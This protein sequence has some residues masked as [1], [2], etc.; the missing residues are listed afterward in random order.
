MLQQINNMPIGRRLSLIV[1]LIS[2][3]T[4]GIVSYIALISTTQTLRN[5]AL[6]TLHNQS[7]QIANSIDRRMQTVQIIL[8]RIRNNVDFEDRVTA[9][10]MNEAISSVMRLETNLIV[11]RVSFYIPG[12]P[13]I[14]HNFPNA[15][16]GRDSLT[17]QINES[18]FGENAWVREVVDS[19]ETGWYGPENSLFTSQVEPTISLVSRY[20]NPTTG[21][22]GIVWADI[23]AS[24]LRA[25]LRQTI[26]LEAFLSAGNPGYSFLTGRDDRVTAIYNTRLDDATLLDIFARIQFNQITPLEDVLFATENGAFAINSPLPEA[27][28]QLTTVLP[29]SALP[30]LPTETVL[31]VVLFTALGLLAMIWAVNRYTLLA[32]GSPLQELSSS[33]QKIGAGEMSRKLS[34]QEQRDEI[35]RVARALEDMRR[36]LQLS[37]DTLEHR[38]IQR[39]QELDIARQQA[40]QTAE[41]LRAV[42]DESLV[43]V[44]NFQLQTILQLFT[45]R[46][47]T[48]LHADYCGIW[49]LRSNGEELR[50]VAHTWADDS[51]T[52]RTA[53]L[54]E[55][56]VGLVAQTMQGLIVDDYLSW[57]NRLNY[58]NLSLLARAMCVPML[59][60]GQAVGAAIVGRATDKPQF[61]ET[62]MRLLTL[63]ANMVSPA[64]KN[65]QLF[66]QLDEAR[67][68]ADQANEVK[69]RFL[70]SVTHELRTPLNLIINN[71]D[72]MRIGAFG[73]VTEEQ[74]GRLDQ[75][76]RSAEHLLYLINDLLDVS[77]IE[78][79]EMQLFIQPTD[80]KPVIEDAL[81]S[82]LMLLEK[83]GK[84]AAV[85]F[86]V[87]TPD[88]LPLVPMDARRIRQ[89]L[90]NLLSNAIKFT[91]EGSVVLTVTVQEDAVHFAVKDTG[92]G[93]PE[94]EQGRLFAAFERTERAKQLAIEGTGLGLPI[95]RHLVEQ[96]GGEMTVVSNAGEGSTFSFTLPLTPLNVERKSNTQIMQAITPQQENP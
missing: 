43:V 26:T 31:Q 92:I 5:E 23:S 96:H 94:H 46:I 16:T 88:D 95:S 83:L 93:I 38:V 84:S 6:E 64:V 86:M 56:L 63:F 18:D 11:S 3:V 51:I 15:N 57:P 8:D 32:V 74:A 81:D 89:V 28:W 52:N 35:G 22:R 55:G 42:Y 21:Q 10:D 49:L 85:S 14:I 91:M 78:A 24:Q 2:I 71:M 87:N 66:V 25:I 27:G 68:I 36:N 41:E 79:G 75:T 90:Y 44:N 65:A 37:Y 29:Y 20:N 9:D 4:I 30:V 53:K 12:E 33:A 67:R 45:Q 70:A 80:L 50:L 13:I 19:T 72:F 73:D 40:Q 39:T 58:S 34:Y 59:S 54:G 47:L 62:D 69:T 48:L 77:K 61:R 7:D 17:R 82:S 60:G 76:I 1:V